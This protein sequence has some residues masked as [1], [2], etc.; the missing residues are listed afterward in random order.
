MRIHAL[1]PG[2]KSNRKI[3]AGLITPLLQT[4]CPIKGFLFNGNFSLVKFLFGSLLLIN[5]RNLV[6]KNL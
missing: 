2:A 4:D 3:K 1:L 6:E 5:S